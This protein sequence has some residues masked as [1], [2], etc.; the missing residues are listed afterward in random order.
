MLV[1]GAEPVDKVKRIKEKVICRS[2]ESSPTVP[3]P[4]AELALTS[5]NLA[6]GGADHRVFVIRREAGSFY[7]DKAF[8]MPGRGPQD[9]I[10]SMPRDGQMEL[11]LG[12]KPSGNPDLTLN[13]PVWQALWLNMRTKPESGGR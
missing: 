8:G 9:L 11:A 2:H 7:T 5:L 6:D 12:R 4:A 1:W 3:H 10:D 13:D